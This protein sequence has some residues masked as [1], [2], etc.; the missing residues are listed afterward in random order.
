MNWLRRHF[1]QCMVAGLV[2]LLPLIGLVI[3]IAYLESQIANS[4]MRE[5]GFYFFGMGIIV[6]LVAVYLVGLAVTTFIGNWL[7]SLIDRLIDRLPILGN[8]Y[9]TLKQ[10]LGY[11]QGPNA[12]FRRVVYIQARDVAGEEIALVTKEP[13]PEDLEQKLTVFVP[14]VPAP[15]TGRMILIAV[16]QT[17]AAGITVNEAMKLLVSIGAGFGDEKK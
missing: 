17:R 11:G 6:S 3:A 5:Q 10:I 12:F 8:L 16:S 15:T 7:W 2:A 13:H 1:V 4:W 9:Q 14:N